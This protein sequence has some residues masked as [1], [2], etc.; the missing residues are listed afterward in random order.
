MKLLRRLI[1]CFSL[2]LVT[3]ILYKIFQHE[4]P[5]HSKLVNLTVKYTK[6]SNT[7]RFL[8]F[9]CSEKYCGGWGE[10]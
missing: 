2:L 3:V 7:N 8:R 10:K 1:C 9:E 4:F 6:C 5:S